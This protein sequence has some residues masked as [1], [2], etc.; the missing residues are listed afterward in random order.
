[1]AYAQGSVSFQPAGE[2]DWVGAV[3]NRPMTTGDRLWA[4]NDGRAELQLDDSFIRLS[5]NT[6]ISFLNLGNNITQLQLSAGYV[7]V[8]VRRLGENDNY[9]VDTP[10]LAFSILRPGVYELN[11]D[12]QGGTT[13][14]KVRSGEGEATGGGTA[15][16]V[17]AREYD[18]FS[19]T[20]QL[21]M[22]PEAYGNEE[23]QFEAW[24]ANRDARYEHSRSERYVSPDV[25][26]YEDL[27][28]NGEWRSTPEYGEVW[29]PR[30]PRAGWAPYRDGHWAYVEPWGYTWVD[31]EPWGFAPFHY[32]RWINEGGAWGWVPSPPQESVRPVYAPALV[33][34]VGEPGGGDVGWFPLGPREV[35]VPSYPVSRNYVENVNV[36]NTTV[37]TTTVNNYYSTTIVNNNTTVNNVQYVNQRV[38]GA[39]TAVPSQAFA[40]AQPV[41]RNIARIDPHQVA[42]AP[43]RVAPPA[44]VPTKQS[45]LGSSRPA[46]AKPPVAVLARPVV[47]KVAPPP[48]RP[49]FEVRQQEIQKNGGKPL[50][51]AQ[52]HKVQAPPPASAPKVTVAPPAKPG[53]P[54]NVQGNRPPSGASPA[55][56]PGAESNRPAPSEPAK[57]NATP[58]PAQPPAATKP[59][60][61]EY[62]APEPPAKA[63]TPAAPAERAEPPSR[64][65]QP[66]YRPPQKAPSAS[67]EPPA[68]GSAPNA[69]ASGPGQPHAPERPV[70]HPNEL[71]RINRPEPPANNASQ[72]EQRHQQEQQQLNQQHQ[73][74]RDQLQRQQEQEHQQ[75]E[76]QKAEQARRQQVEQQ[77]QQQ[78][79]ELQQRHNQEQQTLQEKQQKEKQQQEKKKQEQNQNPPDRPPGGGV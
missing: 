60:Q 19:G 68:K 2:S 76:Q 32:G 50:S 23:D 4:D 57:P 34:W 29:Y 70:V 16:T 5:R 49:S 12:E 11:V 63:N 30:A 58:S 78:T 31:D 54:Q 62:R 41:A 36:S 28:D 26:G 14:I 35:Y 61:P 20:D 43:V 65:G 18:T 55:N 51:V 33:A 77:H 64:P 40:T 48:P 42:S 10:N 56:R 1:L 13:A 69:P 71:P 22:T 7:L 37:N 6:G 25:V 75:L 46:P 53:A 39:V 79:Q 38:P 67:P 47:A 27:D 73:A 21:A 59:G 72:I 3:V 44:V 8:R 24:S 74:E 66:E 9:E 45:V 17:H 15:Y 52:M